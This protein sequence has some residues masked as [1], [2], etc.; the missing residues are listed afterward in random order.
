MGMIANLGNY[1]TVI[2]D[3]TLRA[4]QVRCSGASKVLKIEDT[5]VDF[6]TQ[7]MQMDSFTLRQEALE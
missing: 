7:A 3:A 1:I 2:W 4:E 6:F 5:V